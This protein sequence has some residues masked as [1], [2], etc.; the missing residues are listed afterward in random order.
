MD[1]AGTLR[2]S[3]KYLVVARAGNAPGSEL[4]VKLLSTPRDNLRRGNGQKTFKRGQIQ[5]A[6]ADR[7]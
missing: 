4:Y 2:R 3:A 6:A 1:R 7:E 5:N